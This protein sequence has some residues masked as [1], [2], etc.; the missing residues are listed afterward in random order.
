M[1]LSLMRKHA[2]SWLIKFLIG[3]IAIVFIFYFGY[4]FKGR[5]G[6]K[7]AH[8]N[9]EMISGLEYRKAYNELVERYRIQYRGLWNE[10]LIK[11]LDL[12][13]RTLDNLINQKLISQEAKIL[14]LDVTEDEIQEA[15]MEYPAFQVNGRFSMGRYRTLLSQNR[16]STEDFEAAMAQDSLDRKLRQFLLAF[17]DVT[18]QEILDHYTYTNEKIKISFVQFSPDQFKKSIKPDQKAMEEFFKERRDEYRVPEKIKLGYLMIDTKTFEGKVKVTDQ[19]IKDHYELNRTGFFEP[20]QVRARHILFKLSQEANE[21][22]EKR[23]REMAKLVLEKAREGKDFAALAKEYSE[24]PSKAKGGDVGFFSEGKMAKPFE[25]AAFEL[26]KGEISDLVLTRF[27]Y[28]IIKVEDIKGGRTKSLEEV[29]DQIKETLIAG[30]G[31][32]L[33]HE[34]GLSLMDQMPYDVDLA[35]YGAQHE[36]N[37]KYTGYFSQ[38]EPIPGLGG[39]EPLRKALFS[40]E[41]KETSELSELDGKFYIFQVA[42]KKASYSPELAEVAEK[43]KNR[44]IDH[45]AAEEAKKEAEGFLADLGKGKA[46]NELAKAKDVKPEITEFFKRTDS[47]PKLGN[48]PGPKEAA[49]GLNKDRQ[50]PDRVYENEMGAFVIKWEAYEGIDETEYQKEKEKSRYSLINTK[51]QRTFSSWLE[52]LRKKADIE[53]VTPVAEM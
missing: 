43:V 14:G 2:K 49:F 27:G 24:G 12:K 31:A 29:R 30:A 13:G 11:V 8:V 52:N 51:H 22:K 38:N 15:I 33:A 10:N 6:Q 35:Q 26:K 32:D 1:L 48:N 3:I 34:K 40:L 42:D 17:V 36:Y 9:G 5:E 16:M 7:I 39:G 44:F 21:E 37:V 20:K 50:Y 4:S 19:E 45:L 28:H 47:I 25:D 53:I 18:D 46:W 41:A 23:V